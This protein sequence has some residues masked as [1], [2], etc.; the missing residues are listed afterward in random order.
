MKMNIDNPKLTAYALDELDEPEKST[1]ARA[2]ADSPEAQQFVNEM[3]EMAGLL[4]S[5]FAADLRQQ[6]HVPVNLIDIHDDPWFWKIA[7]PLSIAAALAVF[8]VIGALALGTYKFGGNFGEMRRWAL[9][10][11]NSSTGSDQ[12]RVTLSAKPTPFADIQMEEAPP[13]I[14]QATPL[15]SLA[16]T[17]FEL[18][19]DLRRSDHL[20][21]AKTLMAPGTAVGVRSKELQG[22][23]GIALS[24]RTSPGRIRWP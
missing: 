4:K 2:V 7:R 24:S 22:S 20:A 14:A 18:K 12:I 19:S 13:V 11:K 6:A 5:E 9:G 21:K 23:C 3:R 15:S 16:P 17:L 1:M 8:A 10:G